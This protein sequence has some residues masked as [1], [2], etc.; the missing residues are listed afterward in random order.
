M[1]TTP[2]DPTATPRPRRRKPARGRVTLVGAGTGDPGLLTVPRRRGARRGRPRRR[3]RPGV[4][5]A[6]LATRRGG[7]PRSSPPRRAT[8]AGPQLVAAAKEG[9][10][11]VRLLPGDPYIGEE[12]V[13][14]A[15]AVVKAKQRLEVVPGVPAAVAVTGYAGVPVGLPRTVA[16]VSTTGSTGG[17]WRPR[18]ARSCCCCRP[19]E[20]P[21]PPAR[22]SSTAAAA[23]TDV[24][25][26]VGGTTDDAAHR[27]H[28]AGRR[29]PRRQRRRA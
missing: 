26:T 7:T 25:V 3:R 9:R 18:P 5:E 11:V 23:T 16:R 13:K 27:R 12:G 21:R 22:S 2:T 29:R 19:S 28:D 15:E 10:A 6:V 24:A 1:T 20:V 17:R 14:D 8:V 4:G